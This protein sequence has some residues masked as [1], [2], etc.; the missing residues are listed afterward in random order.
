MVGIVLGAGESKRLGRPKQTL[1]FGDTTLLGH[2]L[3]DVEDSSLERVLLVVASMSTASFRT[4]STPGTTTRRLSA[5]CA[6]SAELHGRLRGDVDR[7]AATASDADSFGHVLGI[8]PDGEHIPTLDADVVVLPVSAED[9]AVDV[10]LDRRSAVVGNL[11]LDDSSHGL[12]RHLV[13]VW[14]ASG[15]SP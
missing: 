10:L 6:P 9:G 1:P 15:R 2:V 12:A 7:P 11:A 5:W 8:H 3:R 14:R 13:R 4:T